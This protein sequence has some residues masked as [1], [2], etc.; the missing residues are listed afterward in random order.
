VEAQFYFRTAINGIAETLALCSM[1]SLADER[2]S[3][4]A[5]GALNIFNYEGERDLVVVRVDSILSVVA[6]VP[7]GGPTESRFSLVEK[8]TFGVIHTGDTVD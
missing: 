5:H 7:F 6:M 2:L 3:E 4:Y 1:Y 8:F